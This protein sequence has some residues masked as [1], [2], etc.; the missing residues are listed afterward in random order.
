[1]FKGKEGTANFHLCLAPNSVPLMAKTNKKF[2]ALTKK[3]CLSQLQSS[4]NIY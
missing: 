2:N 4:K 1:M 3:V